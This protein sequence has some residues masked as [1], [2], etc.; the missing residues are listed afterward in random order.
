MNEQRLREGIRV[1]HN[2]HEDQFEICVWRSKRSSCGYIACAIGHMAMDPW[3]N[4]QGLTLGDGSEFK[5]HVITLPFVNG[6]EGGNATNRYAL[7]ADFFGISLQECFWLFSPE[8]YVEETA[9]PTDVIERIIKLLANPNRT[10]N[11][12]VCNAPATT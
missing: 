12:E 1:L 9:T 7:L 4:A 3:F 8:H 6:E 11:S 5:G 2:V 10:T